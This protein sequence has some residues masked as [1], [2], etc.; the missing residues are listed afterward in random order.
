VLAIV[1]PSDWN[2]PLFFHIGGAMFLVASLI[3]ALYAVPI[4]RRRGDQPAAQFLARVLLWVT[5]PSY[6]VMRIFAQVIASKEHVDKASPTWVGIGFTVSD[7]G[8]V[9]LLAVLIMTGLVARK[10][11]AGTSVA[12]SGQLRATGVIT[13]ILLAAYVVAIWAMTTKPT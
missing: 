9:L 1:R 7:F 3:V 2:L 11:R 8:F 12:G 4:A 5:L 10:T 13:G 6:L